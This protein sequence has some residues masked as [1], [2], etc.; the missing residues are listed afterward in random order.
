MEYVF[1]GIALL[2]F[3]ALIYLAARQEGRS[4]QRAETAEEEV[5]ETTKIVEK[6]NAINK[7]VNALTPAQRRKLLQDEFTD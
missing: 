3:P 7:S 2:V 5:K 4:K 6:S 1:F